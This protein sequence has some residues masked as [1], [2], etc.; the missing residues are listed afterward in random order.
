MNP[1]PM[2]NHCKIRNKTP[3]PTKNTLKPDSR[4]SNYKTQQNTHQ[5]QKARPNC[6][7]FLGEGCLSPVNIASLSHS[8]RLISDVAQIHQM[9]HR[10]LK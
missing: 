6:F 9:S 7:I 10:L 3:L 1:L 5:R 4:K 2:P 8:L